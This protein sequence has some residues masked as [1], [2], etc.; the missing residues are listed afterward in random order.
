MPESIYW[1]DEHSHDFPD[2]SLARKDPDGLLATGGDLTP[3]RII[4]AYSLGIFPW[5]SPG[6]PILWWSPNP[7]SI[8]LPKAFKASRS[9]NKVI[10][11]KTFHITIDTCFEQ[12]TQ[13]SIKI[14]FD[15]I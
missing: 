3:N 4:R 5:Y 15:F 7:R 9:L 11:R 13:F 14:F 10:K 2:V 8:V 1:L 12:H 6:E